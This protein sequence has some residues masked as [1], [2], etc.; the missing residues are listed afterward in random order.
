LQ[1]ETHNS[2]HNWEKFK[3]GPYWQMHNID[4][5]NEI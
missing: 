5:K 1:W 3:T 2:N 4:K